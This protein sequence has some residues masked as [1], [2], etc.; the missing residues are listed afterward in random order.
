MAD[1]SIKIEGLD[2]A[3][4]LSARLGKHSKNLSP[5]FRGP[6]DKSVTQFFRRQWKSA[7]KAGGQAWARLRPATVRDKARRNLTG[8]GILRARGSLRA[9]FVGGAVNRIRIIKK[10]S[11]ERGSTD[12]KAAFHQA[13][14]TAR[15][16][17]GREFRRPRRVPAR[18]IVPD[19]MPS[20]LVKAWEK[21]I[22]KFIEGTGG[23]R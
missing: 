20:P 3:L 21:T 23:V 8:M 18:K 7:G 22:L 4:K 17:G 6:I 5:V 2:K 9:S 13:G 1:I 15:Q 11:Y 10:D 14:W 16:W 12:P 19:R